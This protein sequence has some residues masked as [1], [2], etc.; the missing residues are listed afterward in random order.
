MSKL[1]KK[2]RI[3]TYLSLKIEFRVK[4]Y[5]KLKFEIG[6]RVHILLFKHTNEILPWKCPII[7]TKSTLNIRIEFESEWYKVYIVLSVVHE[8]SFCKLFAVWHILSRYTSVLHNNGLCIIIEQVNSWS[9]KTRSTPHYI[10]L[11]KGFG[12]KSLNKCRRYY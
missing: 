12:C 8:M 11:S 7:N 1:L 3:M 2:N 6:T 5:Q 4:Q 10:Q 9:H